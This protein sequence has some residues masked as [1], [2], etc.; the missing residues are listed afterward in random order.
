M[1][2][3]VTKPKETTGVN[4][5]VFIYTQVT[6]SEEKKKH[7]FLSFITK[8]DLLEKLNKQKTPDEY[9]FLI[10]QTTTTLA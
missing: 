1:T 6:I 8:S 10:K 9:I 7:F 5:D 4:G 2:L 3:I